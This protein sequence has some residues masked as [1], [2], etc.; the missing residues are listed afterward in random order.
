VKHVLDASA[1]LRFLD[2]ESGADIVQ[3][4]LERASRGSAPVLMSAVNWGEIVY[5]LLRARGE[6]VARE[7]CGSLASLA[8]EIVA[9]DAS[10]AERAAF[11][12]EDFKIPYADSYAAALALH[13]NATLVTADYDFAQLSGKLRLKMLPAKGEAAKQ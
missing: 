12:K 11:I 13:E 3:Q 7:V 1:L 2:D 8:I 4:V 5:V 9:V 10:M 6:Q